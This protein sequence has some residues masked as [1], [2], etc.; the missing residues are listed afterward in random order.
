[1]AGNAFGD[2]L[3]GE[4]KRRDWIQA[5]LARAAGMKTATISR[6]VNGLQRCGES[7]CRKIAKALDLPPE[8]VMRE[9]GILPPAR[10]YAERSIVLELIEAA[11]DLPDDDWQE[12]LAL[13]RV[14]RDRKG[15]RSG[16]TPAPASDV[17]GG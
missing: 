9:A 1:M 17:E 6:I 8:A 16:G 2:W 12:L 13:V 3:Q 14:K 11:W 5:D 10:D 4:L 15:H 7:S